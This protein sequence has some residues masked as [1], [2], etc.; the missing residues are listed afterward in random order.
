M[1]K[2]IQKCGYCNLEILRY[3]TKTDT[4]FCNTKCKA[5]WQVLQRELQGYTKEWLVDQYFNKGNDCNKIAKE[6]KKDGK[7]VWNW[8]RGYG[9][10]IN[11]RGTSY[12]NNLIQDGSTFRGKKH[13]QISKD[14]I[15]EARLK[16]GHVPYLNKDGVHWLKGVSGKNHPSWK[17][18]LTPER[19]SVYSSLEWI[20][21]VK[22]VWKRDN[23]ICQ[24]CG[25]NHNTE[26][27]RGNFHIHHLISFQIPEFRTELTNLVLLCKECHIWVHSKK[28]INNKFIKKYEQSKRPN[29]Y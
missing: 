29:T 24:N 27:N 17:G 11:K 21:V 12:K 3:P 4:Y 6:I 28:N 1:S 16:D 20:E 22:E 19:Q 2:K 5:N 25:K 8:F 23:A 18:G 13:K 26:K 10:E 9:I 14:K 15:R 7:T